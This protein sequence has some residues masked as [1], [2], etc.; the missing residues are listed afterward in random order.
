[1][2]ACDFNTKILNSVHYYQIILLLAPLYL[3]AV[4]RLLFT[5]IGSS[6]KI[7][8]KMATSN[9]PHVDIDR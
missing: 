8:T 5:D 7:I 3:F 9:I 2:H 4:V 1:M 6:H